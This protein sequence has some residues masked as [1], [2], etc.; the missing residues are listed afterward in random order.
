MKSLN[1]PWADFQTLR[2]AERRGSLVSRLFFE[3]LRD[4]DG[5]AP[6][7]FVAVNALSGAVDVFE[8]GEGRALAALIDAG[9]TSIDPILIPDPLLDV[10]AARGYFFPSREM[11]DLAFD[12]V[13]ARYKVLK[14]TNDKLL[15]FFAIDTGCPM[16]CEYCFEKK[17][18]DHSDRFEQSVMTPESLDAAFAALD[19]IQDLQRKEIEF[20]AGWGGEPLQE[21]HHRLNEH[22]IARAVERSLSIT[23]FSNLALIGPRTLD[24]LARNAPHI[25][26][27]STTLD[28]PCQQHDGLRRLRGAFERT[29]SS[30]AACLQVG[31]TVA[32]RT[33]LGAHNIGTLPELASFYEAQGWF[34]LPNFRPFVAPTSDRQHD[35]DKAFTLSEDETLSQ[36]LRL[37]DEFPAVRKIQ[38]LKFAPSLA[39]I[40]NAFAPGELPDIRSHCRS[41]HGKPMLTYCVAENRNEYVFTGAPNH[42]IYICAECT[43]LTK[44]RIGTYLPTISFDPERKRMWGL[45][46]DFFGP[47]SIDRLEPCR[48]CRAAT[49]CGGYC[50]LE[51]VVQNGCSDAVFCKQAPDVITAFIRKEGGR[52]YRAGRTV[53]SVG[54]LAVA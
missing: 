51:A 48:S 17:N 35:Y 45:H 12:A 34:D 10:L 46:D 49:L 43:G 54:P 21:R 5:Q 22:F 26:F 31:V 27:L 47:R 32:V 38:T 9:S 18:E 30:I 1:V 37:R 53:Q 41:P 29:A 16:K 25:L 4:P 36:W 3:E 19:L 8:Y 52:L 24:L 15:G 11:E 14:Q 42:S 23:Y 40:I 7:L 39:H 20:V 13:V 28:G 44:F 6:P 33:N 2:P 50:A